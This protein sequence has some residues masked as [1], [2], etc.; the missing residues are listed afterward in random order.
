MVFLNARAMSLNVQ[1]FSGATAGV[2]EDAEAEDG[3]IPGAAPTAVTEAT[4]R[5]KRTRQE[6][7]F[8]I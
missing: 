2:E 8:L 7:L 6:T 5:A 4:G 1:R 3:R